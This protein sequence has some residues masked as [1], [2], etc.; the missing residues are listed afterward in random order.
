MLQSI[1]LLCGCGGMAD[2]ADSKSAGVS[3]CGFKSRHPHYIKGT[4]YILCLFVMHN[5]S[6]TISLLL[7]KKAD[8]I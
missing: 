1:S 3:P 8:S 6:N 4:R 2:A 5:E 7:A